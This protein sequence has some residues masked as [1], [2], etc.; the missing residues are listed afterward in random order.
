MHVNT[1]RCRLVCSGLEVLS[2]LASWVFCRDPP[3]YIIGR[4][5]LPVGVQSHWIP[6]SLHI[7]TLSARVVTAVIFRMMSM[8]L[9]GGAVVVIF[10]CR[11]G[12]LVLW[13]DRSGMACI[14]RTVAL[15][16]RQVFL[17]EGNT[18]VLEE[19]EG[20]FLL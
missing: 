19:L 11:I 12:P 10:V 7:D 5:C 9:G 16:L 13:M 18:A 17:L 2:Q 4:L 3:K 14:L 20:F 15:G 1:V 8:G 6:V